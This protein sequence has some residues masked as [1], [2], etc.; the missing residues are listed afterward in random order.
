MLSKTLLPSVLAV[1]MTAVAHAQAP[2]R[3]PVPAPAKAVAPA[4]SGPPEVEG[5]TV[6]GRPFSLSSRRGKVVLLMYWST[7][8]AVCRDK[9]PELR[10]NYEGWAG[11]PFELVLVSTDR[12]SQD[13]AAYEQ[14]ISRTVP[15][16]QRFVQ[17]WAG[18]PGYRDN[19][20]SPEQLP[21]SWLIDKTGKVVARYTGR[22]P[23]QAWDK[24]AELL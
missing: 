17:L 16:K 7:D 12:R 13:L 3:V 23:P 5:R 24:I 19:L 18:E 15:V 4:P 14:I 2:A 9:M 6:D 21:A 10:Q 20:G 11:Q 1:L 8:C 22:I